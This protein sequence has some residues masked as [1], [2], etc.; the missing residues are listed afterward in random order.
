[1][2]DAPNFVK[3]ADQSFSAGSGLGSVSGWATSISAGPTDE[4]AQT[5][6][7][8]VREISDTSNVVTDVSVS[9]SG[10][11]LFV[12]T[13]QSGTATIGVSLQDNGGTSNGGDDTSDE[14][15]FTI[16]VASG[17]DLSVTVSD[18]FGASEGLINYTI[19]ASNAGPSSATG[20]TVTAA[21]PAGLSS[22]SWTCVA[23]G[24]STCPAA[25]GTGGISGLVD[26]TTTGSAIFTLSGTLVNPV[27]DSVSLTASITPPTGTPDSNMAN[28]SA[29]RTTGIVIFGDDFEDSAKALAIDL[30]KLAKGAM[31]SLN[32]SGELLVA[33]AN[34]IDASEAQRFV[35]K[36]AMLMLLSRSIAGAPQARLATRTSDGSWQLGEWINVQSH[37]YLQLQWLDAANSNLIE[38]AELKQSAGGGKG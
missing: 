24:G 3:G 21:A 36:D 8:D 25:S 33:S 1:M 9:A 11:L 18:G 20:A 5:L 29:T 19:I 28:N 37:E 16:T 35:R 22:V 30:P 15:T 26:L 7:F 32:I 34:G 17:A 38:K 13:G 4:A 23:T 27:P 14:Q 2:N 10:Q 31:G 12:R 6:S